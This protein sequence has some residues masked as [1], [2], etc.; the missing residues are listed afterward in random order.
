MENDNTPSGSRKKIDRLRQSLMD[1]S[2]PKKAPSP[3]KKPALAPISINGSG[4]IV[5]SD[6][7]AVNVYNGAPVEKKIVVVKTGDGVLTA[8]QKAK[9][10][11]LI[12][13]W[14]EAR[15][16]VRRTRAEIAALRS[17]FNKAMKVN[18][19]AEILQDDFDKAIAWLRRQTGIVNS[20]ASAPRK[21]PNWRTGRY[22]AINARAKEFLDGELRYRSYAEERFGSGSLK[23]LDDEQLEA[24]YRHVFGWRRAQG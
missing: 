10:N 6:N 18:S 21:N 7:S 11:A 5:V 4:N 22:R 2:A 8:A 13:E 24:V 15:G 14:V 17:A 12:T 3:G 20:M 16:A 19:Y 9:I 23:D 1:G